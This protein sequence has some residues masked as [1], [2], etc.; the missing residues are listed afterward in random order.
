M[1]IFEVG[2]C[3]PM[4]SA[5]V[6]NFMLPRETIGSQIYF[7]DDHF[8][9]LIIGRKIV[10]DGNKFVGVWTAVWRLRQMNMKWT[11]FCQ[12]IQTNCQWNWIFLKTNYLVW[13]LNKIE[14]RMSFSEVPTALITEFSGTGEHKNQIKTS[15][16]RWKWIKLWENCQQF[17]QN[18]N[19]TPIGIGA[20]G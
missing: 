3:E 20:F 15:S 1:R 16:M 8:H 7:L 2:K 17:Q 14:T 18:G 5:N 10:E 12:S 4:N 13:F 6:V 11:G 19:T 9:G